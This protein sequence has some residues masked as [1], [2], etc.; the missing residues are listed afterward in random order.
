[1]SYFRVCHL[2]AKSNYY[3][4]SYMK[5]GFQHIAQYFQN[6]NFP[7]YS[8]I[9]RA[10]GFLSIKTQHSFQLLVWVLSVKLCPVKLLS[11]VDSWSLTVLTL[12]IRKIISMY[13]YGFPKVLP[14]DRQ[15]TCVLDSII[16]LF[17][18]LR[19]LSWIWHSVL[20]ATMGWLQDNHT[21]STHALPEGSEG[22]KHRR[23][24]K[25][26]LM[27]RPGVLSFYVFSFFLCGL[28]KRIRPTEQHL[29]LKTTLYLENE[30]IV[31]LQE[32]NKQ[33]FQ[34]GSLGLWT[35]IL[36]G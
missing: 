30:L 15:Q 2:T 34:E 28:K 33:P 27:S 24:R 14:L 4:R 11:K 9:S 20:R 23:L 8:E 32:I 19:L 29:E 5:F 31:Y 10:Q 22:C 3:S 7:T 25:F 36:V 21:P 6:L 18:R 1:M 12:F 16:L 35:V 26:S 13:F 17:M